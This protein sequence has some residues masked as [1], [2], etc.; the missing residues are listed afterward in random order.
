MEDNKSRKG[1][2]AMVNEDHKRFQQ[3]QRDL[4]HQYIGDD[5]NHRKKRSMD[6]KYN[7]GRDTDKSPG[8]TGRD[9]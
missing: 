1:Q 2:L 8:A 3:E 6:P 7:T 4:K 9:I 5:N